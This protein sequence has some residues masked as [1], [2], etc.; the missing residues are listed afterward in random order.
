MW[1]MAISRSLAP[2][3][4]AD[5][6]QRIFTFEERHWWYRGVRELSASVL[7]ERL[8]VP[9]ARVLDAGCGTG[10]FLRWLLDRGAFTA[11]AGIDIGSAAIELARW[12]VPEADLRVAPLHELPFGDA[13][14]DLVVTNDVL[15]HVPEDDVA[16]SLL[17]LRRVLAPD[18]TLLLRTNGAR[19]LRRERADWRAY[20]RHTLVAE[21]ERAGFA[22]ER[23]TYVNFALSMYGT[24]RGRSPHAPT[25]SGDGIPTR[26]PGRFADAV[27][28]A[29]LRA[30]ARWLARPGRSLPYGHT[31]IAVAA[32]A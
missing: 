14:F 16:A 13:S 10:G 30:E 21:L 22:C 19:R 7:G 27:G 24:L 26:E 3:I 23:V 1:R 31:L 9:G 8:T 25:E 32:R 28:S 20:D 6:Y 18:G 29:V 5:Y 4:P 11:A 17:E 15:Q 12:R 2:G